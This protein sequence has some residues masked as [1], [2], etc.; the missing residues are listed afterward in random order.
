MAKTLLYSTTIPSSTSSLAITS[1]I[2]STYDVY[3]LH[4]IN[5]HPSTDNVKFHFQV[6]AVGQTGF[7]EIMTTTYFE[8]YHSEAGT[9]EAIAYDNT[10]DLTQSSG[11]QT[12]GRG[13]GSVAD[14]SMRGTLTLYAPS[15]T[16]YVKHFTARSR[17]NRYDN[18]ALDTFVAG[19]INTTSAIDEI[20]FK[21]SSGYIDSGKIKMF[22]VS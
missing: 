14:E 3:E 20:A 19:Y 7:N 2:N 15:S 11:Y 22:G 9:P 10:E 13:L 18:F 16:T 12:L 17:Y 6:N 1:G 4:F 5:M 8:S 21:M